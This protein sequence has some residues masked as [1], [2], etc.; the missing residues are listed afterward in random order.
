MIEFKP[1]P[2]PKLTQLEPNDIPADFA[3][4]GVAKLIEEAAGLAEPGETIYAL[5][6][7]DDGVLWGYVENGN[8]IVPSPDQCDWVPK[9]RTLTIQQCRLFGG[10]GE[11]FIWRIAEGKWR[12]RKLLEDPN[13]DYPKI[14]ESQLLI[15]NREK[16]GFKL[17]PDFMAIYEASTGLRQVVPHTAPIDDDHRLALVVRHYLSEDD[18]GQAIIK[19]SRLAGLEDRD[20]TKEARDDDRQ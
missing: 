19:C 20:L 7:L 14:E 10:N 18:D 1:S 16:A 17:P 8:L 13:V 6:H 15:G 4:E 5:I 11:L 3:R 9:L 2:L 12:G